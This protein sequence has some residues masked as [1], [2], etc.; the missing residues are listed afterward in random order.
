MKTPLAAIAVLAALCTPAWAQEHVVGTEAARQQL[1]DSTAA[2]ARD[3]AA[4]D[5]FV[6][7][8]QGTAALAQLGFDASAVQGRLAGLS[9]SELGDLAARAAALQADPA[10]GALSKQAIWIGVIALAV[11]IIIIAVA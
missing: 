6:K 11:I 7:S 10:A 5:A 2:R 1:L 3:L 8:P 9:D 4:V